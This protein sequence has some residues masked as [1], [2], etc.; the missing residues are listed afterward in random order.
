MICMGGW[1]ALKRFSAVCGVYEQNENPR[2][3]RGAREES[4]GERERKGGRKFVCLCNDGAG[5]GKDEMTN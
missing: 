4:E 5:T 1:V 3:N 2:L